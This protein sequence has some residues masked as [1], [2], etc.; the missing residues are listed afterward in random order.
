MCY[1]SLAVIV[2]GLLGVSILIAP[3][4]STALGSGGA[5]VFGV[6]PFPAFSIYPNSAKVISG[7]LSGQ[8]PLHARLEGGGDCLKPF[9][10]SL[11]TY[12]KVNME[13][14]I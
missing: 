6:L 11:N 8:S 4:R 12:C 9:N 3:I 1:I 7:G 10:T 13:I 2:K 14:V 5:E